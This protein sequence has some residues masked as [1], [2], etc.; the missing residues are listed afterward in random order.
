MSFVSFKTESQEKTGDKNQTSLT[1][2]NKY[3]L[4]NTYFYHFILG[5]SLEETILMW[6]RN[7]NIQKL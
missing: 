3:N 2:K 7:L 5:N 4:I 6:H 1:K